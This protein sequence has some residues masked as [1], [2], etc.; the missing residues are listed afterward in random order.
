MQHN[1]LKRYTH[2]ELA[3]HTH[4]QLAEYPDLIFIYNRTQEDVDRVKY[5]NNKYLTGTITEEEKQEWSRDLI[6]ALNVS[7]LE[8][9]E[10]NSDVIASFFNKTIVTKRWKMGDIP[11]ESDYKRIRDNVQEIRNMFPVSFETLPPVPEQ[12][13]NTFQKWNGLEKILYNIYTIYQAT[14]K[15]QYY[16]DT[17]MYAGEGVGDL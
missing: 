17:E 11:R 4:E 13:L 10:W 15:N 12:S 5:L 3:E 1:L 9:V 14:L 16:C 7:D 6:G 2:K 8:R